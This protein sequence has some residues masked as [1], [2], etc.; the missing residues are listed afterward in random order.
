MLV[1]DDRSTVVVLIITGIKRKEPL[2]TTLIISE[3]KV[4]PN[5][6]LVASS[7]F[8]FVLSFVPQ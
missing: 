8:S 1:G 4:H 7:T 2:K 3:C 5:L 6:L